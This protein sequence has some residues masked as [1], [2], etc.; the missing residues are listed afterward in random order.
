MIRHIVELLVP[1]ATAE[2]F[3]SFMINP[4][5]QRYCEWWQGEHLQFHI[6]KN[7]NSDHLGDVVFMDEHL[8]EKHRLT[9][10]ANVITANYPNKIEW[11]MKK[12]NLR[13]PAIVELEFSDT[14]EGVLLKH[15]VRIGYL[16]VG[17][18]LDPFIR[19]YF[20]KSFQKSLDEHCKIEWFKLAEYLAV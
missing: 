6:V 11:Q 13:L 17:R 3:Y 9:F 14:A 12:A 7:G 5:D 15:I 1:N 8:G 4:C 18:I 16:G 2:Q 10:H 20:N 19:I